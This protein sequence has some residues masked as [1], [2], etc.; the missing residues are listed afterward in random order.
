VLIIFAMPEAALPIKRKYLA[1]NCS[2]QSSGTLPRTKARSR[3]LS[4]HKQASVFLHVIDLFIIQP[5]LAS[6]RKYSAI[7]IFF[8]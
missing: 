2:L 5:F 7:T 3:L 6:F 1:K 8:L 4:Q